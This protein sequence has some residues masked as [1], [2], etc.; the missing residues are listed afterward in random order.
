MIGIFEW[1]SGKNQKNLVKHGLNFEDAP[2]IFSGRLVTVV[3]DRKNYGEIRYI[4]LGAL[5]SRVVVVAHTFRENKIRIIS[6]RKANEREKET[7]CQ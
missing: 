4:S 3:D 2:V 1:D 5:E 6:M 7:Y